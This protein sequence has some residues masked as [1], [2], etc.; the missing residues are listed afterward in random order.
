MENQTRLIEQ[1]NSFLVVGF[2]FNDEHLTPKIDN[3]IKT[4]TPIVIVTKQ[5]TNSCTNKLSDS[6]KYCLFERSE[7]G[8]KITFK[9]QKDSTKA[10]IELDGSYWKLNKFMEIL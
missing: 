1:A 10:S 8:T 5:A 4:G 9:K 3:K 6:E 7:N 2:G